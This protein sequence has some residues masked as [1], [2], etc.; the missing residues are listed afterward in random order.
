MGLLIQE[1]ESRAKCYAVSFYS[2][3]FGRCFFLVVNQSRVLVRKFV[4]N[5]YC[6]INLH[7]HLHLGLPIAFHSEMDLTLP[8]RAS[9]SGQCFP[10]LVSPST[11]L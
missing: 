2:G 6:G 8:A 10:V 7:L 11:H 3:F 4:D 9:Q 1:E 5:S